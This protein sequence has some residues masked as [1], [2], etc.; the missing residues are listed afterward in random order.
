LKKQTTNANPKAFTKGFKNFIA[1]SQAFGSLD[2]LKD[3]L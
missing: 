1:N 2:K 3:E